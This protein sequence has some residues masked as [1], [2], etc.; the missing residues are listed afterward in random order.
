M[1]ADEKSWFCDAWT[2][3]K[4][5]LETMATVSNFWVKLAVGIVIAAGNTAHK[6]IC[7]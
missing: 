4:P 1:S 6:K 5:V 2:N 3:V 7:G